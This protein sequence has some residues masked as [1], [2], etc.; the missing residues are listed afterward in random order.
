[1][2]FT[3]DNWAGADDAIAEA[4]VAESRRAAPA[5]GADPL[6]RK[7]EAAFSELFAREVRVF[8]VG[9]GTAANALAISAYQRPGGVVF[10][11][12]GAHIMVDECNAVE[13][14]SGG[15]K[16]VGL[17]G[18]AG[19]VE[20]AALSAAIAEVPA[21]FVHHGQP[22]ALSLSQT[23]ELGAVYRPEEIAA[24]AALAQSA[25]MKVHVDGARFANAV[26][27]LGVS[28][29]EVTWRAGVD[30]LSFGGSK[31]GCFSA[32]AVVFFSPPDAAQFPYIRKRAGHLTSKSRFI[33]AQFAA[34]L[35]NGR[36]LE[37]AAN[38]NA[39]ARRLAPGLRASKSARLKD[40]PEANELFP[41]LKRSAAARLKEAGAQF[42]EWSVD[43]LAPADRPQ[44]DE[45]LVRLVT[46][47]RT[48][49]AEVDRFLALL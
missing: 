45:M 35:E 38:A 41:I 22:M 25:G 13:F 17:P 20:P 6:T 30:V 46:S 2:I 28:P 40:D 44:P 21:D 18:P 16:L 1:M 4:V 7:V 39:M 49:A 27:A 12:R 31:N 42:S 5:Y 3:S 9:T 11:N 32:E 26:A 24:L 48:E 29:A 36:W 34:Y 14:F 10:C 8:M 37:L 33:A 19:K 47:F 23:T 15:A 43:G